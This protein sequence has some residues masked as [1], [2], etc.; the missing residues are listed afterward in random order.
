MKH[1]N[2]TPDGRK[3]DKEEAN[4]IDDLT[5]DFPVEAL[6]ENLP[7]M[8][9]MPVDE[10]LAKLEKND[11]GDGMEKA[12]EILDEYEKGISKKDPE[13]PKE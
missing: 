9:S 5:E 13:V 10:E 1:Y 12:L 6:S 11:K 7:P 2:M 4:A 8:N 3:V